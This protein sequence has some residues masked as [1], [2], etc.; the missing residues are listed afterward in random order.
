MKKL[1][2]LLLALAGSL[3]CSGATGTH[4]MVG[5]SS[6]PLRRIHII[7]TKGEIYG[8]FEESKFYV[9]KIDPSPDAHNGEC[10]IEEVDLNV[11]GD[12]VGAYGGHG[13]GDERLAADFVQFVRG[14]KP[15]LACTSIFDSVAGHLCV[16][17]ADE[18][19]THGGQ[20]VAVHLD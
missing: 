16:Y 17:L 3:A 6:A 8:N 4:N 9:S 7:G 18:S 15:S 10:Q 5:G 14:E 11:K 13:G 12:M 19:R 20:P 1:S 2:S